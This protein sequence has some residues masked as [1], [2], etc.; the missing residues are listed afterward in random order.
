MARYIILC[1]PERD[2][3]SHKKITIKDI[4]NVLGWK[5]VGYDWLDLTRSDYQKIYSTLKRE[6]VVDKI[7]QK[8]QMKEFAKYN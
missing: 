2:A 3:M 7:L 8:T 6:K 4:Y 1:K 5:P